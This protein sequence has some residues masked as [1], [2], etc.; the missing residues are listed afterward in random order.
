[1]SIFRHE[2]FKTNMTEMLQFEIVKHVTLPLMKLSVEPSFVRF[3]GPIYMAE[4][5]APTRTRGKADDKPVE[6]NTSSRK[7]AAPELAEVFDLVHQRPAQI[8]INTVL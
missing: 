2:R 8:I 4:Q 6:E 3:D 7:M 5:T 1:M